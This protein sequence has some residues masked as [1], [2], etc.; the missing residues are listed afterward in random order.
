MSLTQKFATKRTFKRWLYKASVLAVDI[1][2][3][4]RKVRRYF[5]TFSLVLLS[6]AKSNGM[7]LN[8]F[9]F[10]LIFFVF[11]LFFRSS[12]LLGFLE[13]SFPVIFPGIHLLFPRQRVYIYIYFWY[14][15]FIIFGSYIYIWVFEEIDMFRLVFPWIFLGLLSLYVF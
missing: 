7:I 2:R 8:Q 15:L 3:R 14:V 5:C 13:I 12:P 4:K 1:N 6:I 11:A 9:I 10:Y